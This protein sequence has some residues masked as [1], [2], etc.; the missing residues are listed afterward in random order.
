MWGCRMI[1]L[2]NLGWAGCACKPGARL[3]LVLNFW[4]VYICTV[5]GV[6][7]S[8]ALTHYFKTPHTA[9]S[10]LESSAFGRSMHRDARFRVARAD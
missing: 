1:F 7:S 3:C 4:L 6:W 5:P 8:P 2:C 9:V 10:E